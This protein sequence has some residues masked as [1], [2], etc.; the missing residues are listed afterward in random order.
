MHVDCDRRSH[1]AHSTRWKAASVSLDSCTASKCTSVCGTQVKRCDEQATNIQTDEPGD[2]QHSELAALS[3][4]IGPD[5]HQHQHAPKDHGVFTYDPGFMATAATAERHHLHRRRRGRAAVPRLPDR[6]AGRAQQLPRSLLPADEGRAA[7]AG[8]ARGVQTLDHAPHDAE[9]VAAA[10]LST[11]STTTRTR[12][13]WSRRSSPRSSAFYHDTTDITTTAHREIF[14]HRMIAKLPT[15]AAA[16]YKHSLGQPFVYPRND[17]DYCSEHA[18]HVLRRALRALRGRPAAREGAR[19]A[20]HPAR[21]PRAE[22]QHLDRA[23][24]RQ[25]GLQS[26]RRDLGRRLGAVGPGARRRQRS[27]PRHAREDRRRRRT[28]PS[29]SPRSRTRTAASG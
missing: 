25:H 27:R 13:R 14:A 21:R 12:W 3:G 20:V 23:A 6:A 19:P 26:L 29:S 24:R 9:R 4:T 16:A 10:L 8:G 2:R 17:L 22:R 18:A 11:A 15:I 7:D 1:S 5:V 28:S